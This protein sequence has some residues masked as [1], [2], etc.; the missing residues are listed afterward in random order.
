MAL[1]SD[2]EALLGGTLDRFKVS[3]RLV[4]VSTAKQ[5]LALEVV[6]RAAVADESAAGAI[7]SALNRVDGVQAVSLR[8]MAPGDA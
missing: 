8:R 4:G 6:Y 1:G 2:A 7:V 5:G 3:R